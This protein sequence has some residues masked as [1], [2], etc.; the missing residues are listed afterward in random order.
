MNE[1]K[2]VLGSNLKK[3]DKHVITPDE[4]EEIPELT[5]EFF[6][7]AI[8]NIGGN[9]VSPE[10]GEAATREAIKRGRPKDQNRKVLLSVRYSPEVVDYFRATGFG[11][12]A[13]MNEV[14]KEWVKVHREQQ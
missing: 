13:R 6:E 4:Y 11:W 2:H 10:A 12:Q 9:Q 7:N 3:I 5:D 14:L 8:W 1:N